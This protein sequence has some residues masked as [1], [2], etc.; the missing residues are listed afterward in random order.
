M[1]KTKI[2]AKPDTK[3]EE[4]F[5]QVGR[6]PVQELILSSPGQVHVVYIQDDVR[7]PALGRLAEICRSRKVRF[8]RVSGQELDRL[9]P[10]NHQGV[11]ARV[12]Q[13]GFAD[14]PA[15][16]DAGRKAALPLVLALD[17]VQ[18]PGNLGVLARTLLALGGGGLILPRDRTAALGAVASKA[19]AGA[20]NRLPVAHVVNLSRAL[21]QCS[22]EGFAIYGAVMQGPAKNVLAM[23]PRFPAVLVLGNEDKGIRPNVL[24]RCMIQ[25]FVPM[26]GEM[27]SLNVAQ[28][29]AIC[30]GLF[31]KAVHDASSGVSDPGIRSQ[32]AGQ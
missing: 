31:A 1:E 5:W 26:P 15:V 9:A 11:L 19:S 6:K 2:P 4:G 30:M 28:A 29:G 25:V 14:L 27:Q 16:L 24:K 7:S 12:F 3:A 17:Q 23:R 32:S 8:R 20:L 22:E 18:D 21:E 10:G 13:P